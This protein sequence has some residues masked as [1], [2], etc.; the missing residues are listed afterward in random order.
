MWQ[1]VWCYHWWMN[2]EETKETSHA[3][4]VKGSTQGSRM[5]M[6]ENCGYNYH[7]DSLHQK[8]TRDI[9]PLFEILS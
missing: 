1:T 4:F 9:M 3:R 7:I 2:V 8:K 5:Q 6:V